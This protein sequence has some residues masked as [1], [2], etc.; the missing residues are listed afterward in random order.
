[1]SS[2]PTL[3]YWVPYGRKAIRQAI[4]DRG[5][6]KTLGKPAGAATADELRD[7]IVTRENLCELIHV[8]TWP[9]SS[10]DP[11]VRDSFVQWFHRYLGV[12]REMLRETNAPIAL[13]YPDCEA[14]GMR[15]GKARAGRGVALLRARDEAG[16]AM[17]LE[18]A[19]RR[20]RHAHAATLDALDALTNPE[21]PFL[22]QLSPPQRRLL[23][24]AAHQAI[25]SFRVARIASDNSFSMMFDRLPTLKFLPHTPEIS[26]DPDESSDDEE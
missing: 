7:G 17:L 23:K 26:A 19:A 1:M 13:I 11:M 3:R 18:S 25:G 16:A 12:L 15:N 24:E 20:V 2:K 8:E 9:L 14:T 22:Q 10:S 21:N 6:L 5:V 4:T